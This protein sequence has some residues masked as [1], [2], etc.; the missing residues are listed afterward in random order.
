MF[1]LFIKKLAIEDENLVIDD[2]NIIAV[3]QFKVVDKS[4][5]IVNIN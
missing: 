3:D 4:M 5:F 2:N 1:I